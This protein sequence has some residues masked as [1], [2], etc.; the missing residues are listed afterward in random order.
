MFAAKVEEDAEGAFFVTTGTFGGPAIEYAEKMKIK[1]IDSKDLTSLMTKA[2]P[3][4]TPDE[5]KVLCKQ[6][7]DI[8]RFSIKENEVIRYCVNDHPVKWNNK[9]LY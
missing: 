8:L 4:N 9:I 3:E 5:I 6:C 1:L 7:G 2:F